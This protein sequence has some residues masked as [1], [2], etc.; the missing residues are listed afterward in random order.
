MLAKD[1]IWMKNP[2]KAGTT[3][4]IP[5]K[6]TALTSAAGDGP[7]LEET[8]PLGRALGPTLKNHSLTPSLM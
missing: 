3:E 4:Y 2:E 5:H 6:T 7:E 1:R 8:L